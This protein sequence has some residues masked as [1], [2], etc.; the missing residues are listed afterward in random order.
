ML[1]D[2]FSKETMCKAM[3][4][5]QLYYWPAEVKETK[6]WGNWQLEAEPIFDLYG[7]EF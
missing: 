2:I 4:F 1:H 7:F 3:H 5:L 6:S